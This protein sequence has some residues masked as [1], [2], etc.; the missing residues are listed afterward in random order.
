MLAHGGDFSDIPKAD[1][2]RMV[3]TCRY[4]EQTLSVDGLLYRYPPG[5]EYDGVG[6]VENLFVICSYWLVDYLARCGDHER[7]EALYERLIG[8]GNHAG[9]FSEQVDVR[10]Q[11]P[12]G[13]FPQAFS[14]VGLVIAGYAL[15]EAR[16]GKRD[17]EIAR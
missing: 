5:G 3:G 13:N 2:P 16:R 1:D 14:H 9:L 6:G 11:A 17:S 10:S 8:L 4:I 15:A 7:A 12:L